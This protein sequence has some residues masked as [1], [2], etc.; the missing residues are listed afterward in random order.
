[1]ARPESSKG[2]SSVRNTP[3]ASMLRAW[4]PI[5]EI[6]RSGT[7][8]DVDGSSHAIVLLEAAGRLDPQGSRSLPWATGHF[9]QERNH[10]VC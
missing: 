6:K 9:F 2:V 10:H 5:Q 1:V 4:H 8:A 7:R 3:F